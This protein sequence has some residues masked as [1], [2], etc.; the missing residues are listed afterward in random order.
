MPSAASLNVSS[1]SLS[2][3][4]GVEGMAFL[5]FGILLI[6]G[7]FAIVLLLSDMGRFSRFFK[8]IEGW[9]NSLKYTAIGFAVTAILIAIYWICTIVATV[10]SGIDP[11]WIVVLVVAYIVITAIGWVASKIWDRAASMHS[12]YKATE[13]QTAVS[14]LP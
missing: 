6:V 5:I 3:S 12:E 11:F 1:T 2:N 8:F 7:G 4:M 9:V 10:G 14:K 13:E